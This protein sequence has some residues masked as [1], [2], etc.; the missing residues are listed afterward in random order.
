MLRSGKKDD[1]SDYH[2]EMTTDVR[3]FHLLIHAAT[4]HSSNSIHLQVFEQF[5]DKVCVAVRA[6]AN[7][8][9]KKHAVIILDNASYHCRMLSKIPCK[10]S[11]KGKMMEFLDANRIPYDRRMKRVSPIPE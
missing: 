11:T 6:V 4:L 7:I 1:N 3:I 8:E 9:G 2:G 10:S 5:F